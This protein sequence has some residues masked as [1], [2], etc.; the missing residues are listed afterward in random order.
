MKKVTPSD[1][2]AAIVEQALTIKRKKELYENVVNINKE[3]KQLNEVNWVG[4]FGFQV[5]GDQS[6]KSKT[7]SYFYLILYLWQI[8]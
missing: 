5:A 7:G 1:I 4:S 3:L 2:R 6:Q 8:P